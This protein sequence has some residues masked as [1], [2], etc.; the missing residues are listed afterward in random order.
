[1]DMCGFEMVSKD[2]RCEALVKRPAGIMTNAE[3]VAARLGK[4]CTGGH[5]HV[6]L[7]DGRA[8]A[9]QQ[10]HANLC[11]EICKRLRGQLTAY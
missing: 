9:A 4:Q 2:E 5:K 8:D 1:M 3:H 10:Y 11:S 7:T 6:M